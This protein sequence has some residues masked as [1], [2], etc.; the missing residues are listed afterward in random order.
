M[1]F[2]AENREMEVE[3]GKLLD[4]LGFIMLNSLNI[5]RNCLCELRNKK[6]NSKFQFGYF[7][8]IY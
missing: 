1:K 3:N 4:S 2:T 7:I 8:N 5:D 6:I